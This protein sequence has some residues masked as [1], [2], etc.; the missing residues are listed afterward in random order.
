MSRMASELA[1]AADK[2]GGRLRPATSL[3][4]WLDELAREHGLSGRV[5]VLTKDHDGRTRQQFPP[6]PPD[7]AEQL[8]DMHKQLLSGKPQ[9]AELTSY[10][11]NRSFL[12]AVHPLRAIDGY[13]V[14]MM[15]EEKLAQWFM[16]FKASRLMLA[17][18]IVLIGWGVVYMLMRRLIRPIKEAG[19][20]AK[21]IVAGDYDI[22]L[23]KGYREQEVHELM[24]SFK[25]MADRLSWLESM[26]TQLL[27]GVT[28]ELKTPVAS[29]SGLVQA[30]R[31]GVVEGEEAAA[32]LDLSLK[33]CLRLQRMI[34]DLLDFN[35]FAG[36]AV[37][38]RSEACDL[39]ATLRAIVRSWQYAE[40]Q[41]KVE[42]Q[43]ETDSDD[44]CQTY[45]AITDPN[46]LQ[47]L[48]VNLLN[49]A[50]DASEA[51]G[52][53]RVRLASRQ[54]SYLIEVED[55]GHGIAKEEQQDIFEPFYRGKHKKSKLR[56][57]GIGLPYSRL[58]ARSLGG[59]LQLIESTAEG[60]TL[61]VWLPRK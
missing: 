51:G 52:V 19:A 49:N 59:E 23:D 47:Q 4:K 12:A 44:N 30:V 2:Y 57:L 45:E 31:Q 53:V 32:F 3:S 55:N 42:V 46:R 16:Y 33:E 15:Q 20:A 22:R 13:V 61:A 6:E 36:Q 14:L 56:G 11:D 7:E 1:D 35:S 50:R 40:E 27:A 54:D 21:Q 60:T 18:A 41:A 9:M 25:E 8:A 38:I 39:E 58:I 34:E 43:I 26:R 5:T 48:I 17:A 29:I 37:E 28:H 10:S 24:H